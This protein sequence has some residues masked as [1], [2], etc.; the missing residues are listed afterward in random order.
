M[1]T[2]YRKGEYF[3]LPNKTVALKLPP[4]AFKTYA[5]LCAHADDGGGC[6]P[7]IKKMA[8]EIDGSE[9]GVK[10]QLKTLREAGLVE[11]S[12]R[13]RPDGSAR[14]NYYQLLDHVGPPVDPPPA[15]RE[16]PLTRS[17]EL[18][19]LRKGE[20]SQSTKTSSL[21][22]KVISRYKLF[23]RNHDQIPGLID[24]LVNSLGES[25]AELYL[26]RLLQRD[27][28]AEAVIDPYVPQLTTIFDIGGKSTKIIQHFKK[29][30]GVTSATPVDLSKSLEYEQ[31]REAEA[32]RIRR[33]EA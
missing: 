18:S 7:S 14:S 1:S 3:R 30:K 6:F 11:V 9:S 13:K 32:E 15:R 4:E 2:P 10:R 5:V 29:T 27:I 21:F 28:N 24:S 22:Y 33:G 19:L 25:T 20:K 16:P 8:E 17:I 31:Q 23:V 12:P 26:T